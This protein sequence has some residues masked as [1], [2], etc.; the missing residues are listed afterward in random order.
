MVSGSSPPSSHLPL[1]QT[2]KQTWNGLP[3]LFVSYIACLHELPLPSRA[4]FPGWAALGKQIPTR[5]DPS[6]SPLKSI[7]NLIHAR[8]SEST[9]RP[10]WTCR[11]G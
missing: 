3:A 8:S 10:K 5:F 6:I 4:R 1:S 2:P 7:V 11:Q 9:L